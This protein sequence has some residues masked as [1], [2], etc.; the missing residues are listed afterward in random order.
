M[1]GYLRT[2]Q[3]TL[4]VYENSVSFVSLRMSGDLCEQV[5]IDSA[6]L[7]KLDI[8]SEVVTTA[9]TQFEY[10][11][12]SAKQGHQRPENACCHRCDNYKRGV[13]H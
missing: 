12:F 4:Y 10:R 9:T 5:A 7:S 3:A 2:A 13:A 11:T 6:E 8:K 1:A